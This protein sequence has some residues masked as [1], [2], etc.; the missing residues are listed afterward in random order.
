MLHCV[1][2]VV[3]SGVTSVYK[4]RLS[5]LLVGAERGQCSRQRRVDRKQSKEQ[6]SF[7]RHSPCEAGTDK[8]AVQK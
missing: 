7:P 4:K 8:G 6:R 2:L 5:V 3:E 1:F